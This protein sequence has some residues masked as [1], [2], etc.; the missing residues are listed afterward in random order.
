MG[1]FHEVASGPVCFRWSNPDPVYFG[2]LLREGRIRVN[3]TRIRNPG[4]RGL[5]V[6]LR[7]FQKKCPFNIK[8]TGK[9]RGK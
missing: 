4:L 3:S 8:V 7:C 1:E 9:N 6:P 2:S 5:S